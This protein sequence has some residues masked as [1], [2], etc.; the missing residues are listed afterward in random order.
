MRKL[1]G[2]SEKIFNKLPRSVKFRTYHQ[3]RRIYTAIER[4]LLHRGRDLP[5][6][7]CIETNSLCTRNC[8]YC[9]RPVDK[10]IF[11]ETRFFYSVIDQLKEWDFKGRI[12][13]HGYCEPLLDKRIFDFISYTRKK[14]PNSEIIQFTNGDLL[15]TEIVEKLI[16]AGVS[17]IRISRHDPISKEKE[18][19]LIE[20]GNRY[21]KVTILDMRDDN[22]LAP[23]NKT[24]L[25]NFKGEV[26]YLPYCYQ[27]ETM[28]V[29]SDGNIC[30]CCQDVKEEYVMGNV[31]RESL[32]TIWDSPKFKRLRV[33][34]RQGEKILPICQK[35]GF[36]KR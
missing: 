31:K 11:I 2:L 6:V 28:M 4:R 3:L 10:K 7:V 18:L 33:D 25:I 17:E 1:R 29:R 19:E 22:R 16:K 14:L 36:E 15:T 8:S 35:C 24:D 32:A 34:I 13:P 5:V 12:S 26:Q 23:L 30:L 20:L 27:I 9:P 21:K